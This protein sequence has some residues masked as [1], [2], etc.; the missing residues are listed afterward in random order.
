MNV[1]QHSLATQILKSL[2]LR[3]AINHIWQPKNKQSD[4]VPGFDPTDAAGDL[5]E[6][7]NGSSEPVVNQKTCGKSP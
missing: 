2:I 7:K 6:H 5:K 3:K 4:P 1:T